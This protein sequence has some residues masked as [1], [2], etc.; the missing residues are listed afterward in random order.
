MAF[1]KRFYHMVRKVI[2]M[3]IVLDYFKEIAKIPHATYDEKRISDFLMEFAKRHQLEAE[4]DEMYNVIM[5]KPSNLPEYQGPTVIL[6]A[7]MDMVYVGDGTR[8][9]EDGLLL[10]EKDGMLKAV[11]TTLGADNGMAV[12]Y[13]LAVLASEDF[14]YPNLEVVFTVQEEDGLRG[15]AGLDYSKLKGS[16]LINMDSEEEQTFCTGCAG[17]V[18]THIKLPVQDQSVSDFVGY[19]VSLEGLQGGH[20][21]MAIHLERGNAIQMCGRILQ[22]IRKYA[23]LS[24]I[25]CKGHANVISRDA[26]MVLAV[27]PQDQQKLQKDLQQFEREFQQELQF[28][29]TIS[30]AVKELPSSVST[31]FSSNTVDALVGLLTLMPNGVLH[32]NAAM[33]GLVE[34]SNNMGS[35]EQCGE[36]LV[37]TGSIRSSVASRKQQVVKQ[38]EELTRLCG[39]TIEFFGDYPHWSYR[40]DSPLRDTAVQVYQKL[41]GRK[42]EIFAVHAGLECG[43]FAQAMPDL[44]ILSFGPDLHFVH[45]VKESADLASV[46]RMWKF[47]R[48]LLA[49]LANHIETSC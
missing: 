3:S 40:K 22:K 5:R 33:E 21:G 23:C 43:Y 18:R 35:L 9:Y 38:L 41:Y 25:Q 37:L 42:P 14:Y 20:S 7:H 26:S 49:T 32:N 36:A 11:G 4:Q 39:G 16:C 15:A 44:D 8:S 30:I 34:T 19:H 24:K 47:L 2:E 13:Y 27:R 6:Q 46:K 10:E 1:P 17:G 45:T 12:A 29:D 48:E 31:V 28:S